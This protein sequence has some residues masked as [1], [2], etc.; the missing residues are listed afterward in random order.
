MRVTES[1]EVR[2]PRAPS[3]SVFILSSGVQ[4]LLRVRRD[5]Y[6]MQAPRMLLFGRMYNLQAH[7]HEQRVIL[8]KS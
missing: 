5:Q 1:G 4:K 8:F 7:T 6:V 3:L 2:A